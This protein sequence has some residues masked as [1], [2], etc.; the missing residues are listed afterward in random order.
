MGQP[1]EPIA[2]AA[3]ASMLGPKIG[4]TPTAASAVAIMTALSLRPR[5]AIMRLR[6]PKQFLV[7]MN[8]IGSGVVKE[9]PQTGLITIE[10]VPVTAS[11][12]AHPMRLRAGASICI[13]PERECRKSGWNIWPTS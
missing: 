5:I 12:A 11:H 3:C 7:V 8:G 2:Q 6:C 9:P 13:L 4:P 1:S 10:L